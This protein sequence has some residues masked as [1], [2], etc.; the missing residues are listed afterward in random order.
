MQSVIQKRYYGSVNVFWL[1]KELLNRRIHRAAGRLVSGNPAVR[2]V[3]LFGSFAKDRATAFSDIDI[4]LIVAY[5]DKRFIDRPDAFRD[6]FNDIEL[7]VDL[8]VYTEA[9]LKRDIPVV[10]RALSEGRCLAKR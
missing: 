7:Q 5:S 4:L 1:N 3:V 6:Y 2:E 8:F 9:E 10:K